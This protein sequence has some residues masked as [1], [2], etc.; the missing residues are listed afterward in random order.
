M[1]E[2]RTNGFSWLSSQPE[3]QAPQAV[4]DPATGLPLL[5][6]LNKAS[7]NYAQVTLALYND[8]E[9]NFKPFTMD[10]LSNLTTENPEIVETSV[11]EA[12]NL[13]GQSFDTAKKNQRTTMSRLGMAP[14][15]QTQA[16]MDRL[17]DLEKTAT[18]AGAAN[19]TRQKLKER[20]MEIMTT[21][22]PNVAGRSYGM[23]G[24]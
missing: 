1:A 12:K 6:V 10:L 5:S 18:M 17:A 7:D 21:G 13:V 14:D 24:E 9:Q 16:S 22:V 11:S 23:S 20:D 2:E 8:W 4:S 19:T 3:E 15:A